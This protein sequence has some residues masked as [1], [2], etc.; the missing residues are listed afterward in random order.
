MSEKEWT[1]TCAGKQRNPCTRY[2]V[3]CANVTLSVL[4]L[5]SHEKIERTFEVYFWREKHQKGHAFDQPRS[6]LLVFI[7]ED[8][9]IGAEASLTLAE[10][11]DV[12]SLGYEWSGKSGQEREIVRDV[13]TEKL[14]QATY[15]NC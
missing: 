4:A 15:G 2:P 5:L 12:S 3:L 7:V 11:V 14:H 1:L 9:L 10:E 6:F 13:L 8:G